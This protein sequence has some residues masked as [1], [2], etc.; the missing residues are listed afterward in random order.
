MVI[1]ESQGEA[2]GER[3]SSKAVSRGQESR[4]QQSESGGADA[5]ADAATGE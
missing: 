2:C 3:E 1:V 4:A 5:I